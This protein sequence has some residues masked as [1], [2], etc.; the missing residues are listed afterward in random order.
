MAVLEEHPV[1]NPD[2]KISNQPTEKKKAPMPLETDGALNL[3][4]LERSQAAP[5]EQKGRRN[6]LE[7]H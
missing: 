1:F 6:C 3:N 5:E 4:V 2:I 7:E